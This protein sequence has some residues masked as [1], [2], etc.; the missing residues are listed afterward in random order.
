[1]RDDT[2]RDGE[3]RRRSCEC[4]DAILGY[5][6]EHP[7]ACDTQRGITEWWIM[8]QRLRVEAHRVRDALDRLVAQGRLQ[9]VGSGDSALYRLNPLALSP[10]R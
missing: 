9:Q 5:L 8:R 2:Q 7:H 6:A 4:V 3:E 10:R 1:M